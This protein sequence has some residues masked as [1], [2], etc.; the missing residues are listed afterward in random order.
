MVV[1]S[2]EAIEDK[3]RIEY[4]LYVLLNTDRGSV[5]LIRDFGLDPNL[6]DK[7]ITIIRAGIFTEIYNQIKKY[8]PG[9]VLKSA[10]CNETLEGLEIICEVDYER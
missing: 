7:P 5:P 3:N 6:V 9:L 1:S 4:Q 8:I 2:L 10:T